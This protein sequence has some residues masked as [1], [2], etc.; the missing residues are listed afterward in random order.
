MDD[1]HFNMHTWEKLDIFCITFCSSP[2]LDSLAFT[3]S[4]CSLTVT[5]Q[6]LP[7]TNT[8]HMSANR[9]VQLIL[10]RPWSKSSNTRYLLFPIL[11][12]SKM[13]YFEHLKLLNTN[14][15]QGSL[16]NYCKSSFKHREK[17]YSCSC[18][19]YKTLM[20]LLSVVM[21]QSSFLLKRIFGQLL[22]N[23]WV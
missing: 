14:S 17:T 18:S 4:L 20:V 22:V 12:I 19:T 9:T 8:V 7:I 6:C 10:L 5:C 16:S 3:S 23:K 21:I 15:S 1:R 13:F 11:R 2:N